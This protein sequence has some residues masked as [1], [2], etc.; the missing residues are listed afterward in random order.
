MW[1]SGVKENLETLDKLLEEAITAEL[2]RMDTQQVGLEG[3][4]EEE[5]VV[6]VAEEDEEKHSE[7]V[8]LEKEE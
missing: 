3:G 5:D 6:V 4:D 8:E 2:I 7:I 1:N